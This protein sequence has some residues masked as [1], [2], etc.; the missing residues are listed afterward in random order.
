MRKVNLIPMAGNGQRFLDEGLITPKPLI[1]INGLPMV[2]RAASCLP[3]A[4]LWIFICRENHIKSHNIDII[5]KKHFP[6]SIILSAN[7]PTD[8]QASTCLLASDH[9]R[10]D[11]ILTIGS[12][13]N[14]MEYEYNLFNVLLTENDALIWTFRNNSVVLKNPKM[15]GWVSLYGEGSVSGVSCKQPISKNPLYDHAIIGAFTFKAAR[16]F[17][18]SAQRTIKKNRRINNEQYGCY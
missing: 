10:P 13:D 2:I 18:E 17:I 11:D 4:D 3:E 9:L 7:K 8:G 6:K 16:I 1:E 14:G 12:C 15:Y 5:I